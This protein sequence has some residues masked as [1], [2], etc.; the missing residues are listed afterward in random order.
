M[1]KPSGP[2][3]SAPHPFDTASP[4]EHL[5][6]ESQRLAH[7]GSWTYKVETRQ[8]LWSAEMFRIYGLTP[9]VEAPPADER[10]AMIHPDDR[11][12]SAASIRT[13]IETGR[14]YKIELRIVR[15]DGSVRIIVSRGEAHRDGTGRVVEL[16][17]TVQDITEAKRIEEELRRSEREL[18]LVFE[19]SRDAILIADA[20]NGLVIKANRAAA[21]LLDRPVDEIIG[22]HQADIHP[23]DSREA[24]VDI[25]RRHSEALDGAPVEAEIETGSGER[26]PVEI[27]ASF[28]ALPDGR[29]VVHGIFRDIRER[30]RVESAL[31]ETESLYR[32]LLQ[33][34]NDTV[35]VHEISPDAPGRFLE[36]NEQAS[37]MLGYTMDELAALG[38]ADID[39]PEQAPRI[40]A[41]IR[42]LYET[43]GAIFATEW[44]AKDG[45]RIPVEISTRLLHVHGRPVVLSIGRDITERV[46]ADELLRQSVPNMRRALGGTINVIMATVNGAILTRRATKGGWPTWPERSAPPWA[47]D[48]ERIEGLRVAGSIHDIGKIAVPL[49]ILSKAT[50]L[51]ELE[52]QLIREH[53]RA[54]HDIL[55]DVEFP[56]RWPASSSNITSAKTA[57]GTPTASPGTPSCS[58]PAS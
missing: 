22:M 6:A 27:S 35:F 51:T 30:K 2:P 36:F 16:M 10:A 12:A 5:L 46:R 44:R 55:K 15:P 28:Y 7:I 38:I 29:R 39:V 23:V 21:R 37:R 41:I 26:I 33:N 14:P 31:H 52:M 17:G 54:G 43:G 32:L 49:E 11:A 9:A 57:R 25:F 42:G 3:P 58:S 4:Q 47:L 24:V 1:T 20:A 50:R 13:A 56:G 34:A 45:R 40:P 8:A 48:G 53:S 19:N 18:G